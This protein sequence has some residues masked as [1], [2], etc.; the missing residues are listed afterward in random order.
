MKKVSVLVAVYNGEAWL[1]RCLESLFSQTYPNIEIVCV[2]DASTDGS[3]QLIKDYALKYDNLKFISNDENCGQAVSRNRAFDVS[4]GDYVLMVDCDDWLS[5]DAVEQAVKVLDAHSDTGIVLLRLL[6]HDAKSGREWEFENKCNKD[7]LSGVEA[8]RL[9][10]NWNLHGLYMA[11]RCLYEK[12]P[13]DTSARLYSDDNTTR[14]HYLHS[15]MVRFCEGVY[16]YY[17]HDK[18]MTNNPGMRVTDW[19]E[20]TESLKKIL[21]AEMPDEE[22]IN[23]LEFR[24]WEAVVSSAGFYWAHLQELVPEQRCDLWNRIRRFHDAMEFGRLPMS[25]RC[26]FGFIPF[27]ECFSLFMLQARIYFWLRRVIKGK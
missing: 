12:Y 11:R 16:Y 23:E 14:R 27:R 7:V 1:S 22:L 8:M 3:L 26:K 5:C 13:F 4:S 15:N 20:A 24:L 19:M 9:S 6:Y 25:V 21:I 18:S 2:D 17:Q 10:L